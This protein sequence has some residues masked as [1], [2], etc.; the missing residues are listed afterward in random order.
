MPVWLSIL[1]AAA[2]L[3]ALVA[4]ARRAATVLV[5]DVDEG[6]I[7]R[8]RGR[9]PGELLRDLGDVVRAA[10]G[11]GRIELHLEDG[12]VGLRVSGLAPGAQQQVRNVVG[13]FP[14]ARLRTAPRVHIRR[15]AQREGV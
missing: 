12:G 10:G 6:R 9:A 11:T 8:A 3:L 1:F 2:L 4:A 14:A 13:R 15:P 5:V 7:T